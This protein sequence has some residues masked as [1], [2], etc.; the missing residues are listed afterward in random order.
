MAH[1]QQH[2]AL[3][4]WEAADD[5]ACDAGRRL[6]LASHGYLMGTGPR[7]TEEAALHAENLRQVARALLV[8]AFDAMEAAGK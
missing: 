3:V 6:S 1:L 8:Q 7:P 2:L 5:A 4:D